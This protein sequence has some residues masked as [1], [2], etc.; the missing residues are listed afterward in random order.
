VTTG[1]LPEKA[2]PEQAGKRS[3]GVSEAYREMI[4]LELSRGRN[5][6]GIWQDMVDTHGFA[7]GYQSVKRLVRSFAER[8]R[9]KRG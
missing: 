3:A 4:E 8:S 1:F 5:A 9:R 7:G 6:T 2:P